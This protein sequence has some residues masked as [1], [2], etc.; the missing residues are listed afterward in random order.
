MS[1][2]CGPRAALLCCIR[3]YGG[4]GLYPVRERFSYVTVLRSRLGTS[5]PPRLL[6]SSATSSASTRTHSTESLPT[7]SGLETNPDVVIQAVSNVIP[8]QGELSS[9]G[10]GGYTPVG[11][12]QT[13]LELLHD[14]AH[15]SWWLSIVAMTVALKVVLFLP[16]VS[17][18]INAVKL[19]NLQP[20]LQ[21]IHQRMAAYRA[22]GDQQRVIEESQKMLRL[23]SEHGCNPLKMFVMPLLQMPIFV[24]FFMA[25]RGMAQFPVHSM[26]TG[27]TLWFTDLTIPDPTFAL[28]VLACGSFILNIEVLNQELAKLNPTCWSRA[29]WS[30]T[31][32]TLLVAVVLV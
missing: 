20:Q 2:S 13:T 11:L 3:C 12:I 4:R 5:L 19:A 30:C 6:S 29:V 1:W 16:S 28:P 31:Q 21:E 14:H 23:Y 8:Q 9:L 27:G 18:Q 26:K 10:L 15:L 22:S 24:S 32:A 25:L 17:V 7:D